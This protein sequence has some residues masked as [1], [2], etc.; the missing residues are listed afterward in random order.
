M[1]KKKKKRNGATPTSLDLLMK[2]WKRELKRQPVS[3]PLDLCMVFI[4]DDGVLTARNNCKMSKSCYG[5]HLMHI[6]VDISCWAIIYASQSWRSRGNTYETL[7]FGD[8]YH[9]GA[10]DEVFNILGGLCN[11][12]FFA[13]SPAINMRQLHT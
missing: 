7:L 11:S 6:I 8:V 1:Q 3:L 13:L 5:S 9:L 4:S 10:S 12:D 2:L